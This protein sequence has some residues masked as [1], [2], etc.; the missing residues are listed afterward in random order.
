MEKEMR[1]LKPEHY[2]E[3]HEPQWRIFLLA[4][5][6]SSWRAFSYNLKVRLYHV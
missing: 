5:N 6:Y 4:Q 1:S 3:T 2:V